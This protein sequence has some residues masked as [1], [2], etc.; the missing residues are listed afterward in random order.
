MSNYV[1]DASAVLALL[2]QE[3]G[4]NRVSEILGES[5]ISA[6]NLSE[7]IAKLIEKNVSKPDIKLVLS[8]LNLEVISF[9][10]PLALFCAHLRPLTRDL[11]LSLGD[12]ACLGLAQQLNFTAVTTDKAWGQ[13]NMG[14]SIEVVR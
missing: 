7:V 5:V 9:D 10:E 6:I 8:Y 14:I 1:L 11:G 12:R 13:L 3:P 2:N 4:N